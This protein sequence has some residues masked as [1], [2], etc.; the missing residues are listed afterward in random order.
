[1]FSVSNDVIDVKPDMSVVATMDGGN[2]QTHLNIGGTSNVKIKKRKP[3]KIKS[4]SGGSGLLT[5]ADMYEPGFRIKNAGLCTARTRLLVLITSAAAPSHSQNRQGIRMT[6]MNR[7]GPSVSMAFLVGTPQMSEKDPVARVLE[8]EEQALKI[9]PNDFDIN[10]NDKSK[11]NSNPKLPITIGTGSMD[12]LNG[13]AEW[14]QF[15]K[16]REPNPGEGLDSHAM[17]DLNEAE[18]AVQRVLGREHV[19]YGDLIQCQSRDTYTNLTLKSIAALEWTRQY[20]PWARYLLKTDDDMF[21]DMRRLLRFIDNVETESVKENGNF[22]HPQEPLHVDPFKIIGGEDM[23]ESAPTPSFE[24]ELPPTI[25]GRL[26]HGWRPIRQNS[27]KYYVSRIQYPGRVYPDFCT[28]PA[29]LMT[30]SAVGPLYEAA[31]G[32]DFDVIDDDE[33]KVGDQENKCDDNKGQKNSTKL[34]KHCVDSNHTLGSS[35]DKIAKNAEKNTVPYLKLEDVY[36]TG[37]VAER[38]T[39]RAA[40]RQARRELKEKNS[41]SKGESKKTSA[42]EAVVDNERL[43][44]TK[45]TNSKMS[46]IIVKIRR[47]H[48]EQFANKKITGRALDKAVCS[49]GN[50]GGTGGSG[51]SSGF[52]WFRWYWGDTVVDKNSKKKKKDLGVISI[53]MVSYSEQFDLWRRLMD[54]RTKCKP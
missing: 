23:F 52:S 40:K 22:H 11:S 28:G 36:L 50:S 30:R 21:I 44:G 41:I 25:W 27:S 31:L 39:L 9:R 12:T 43:D 53:H 13:N 7:Y 33:D 42:N 48:D 29:Y 37:V 19:R 5:A 18:R 49:G 10:N 46:D 51:G 4:P 14:Y 17:N 26:A 34:G 45:K 1:M 3:Q 47:I 54:G 35:S 8:A 20:C 6:W 16:D 32:R 2:P 15:L 24:M 38:L